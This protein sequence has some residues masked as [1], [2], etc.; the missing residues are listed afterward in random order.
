MPRTKR[1]LA[2]A[3]SNSSAPAPA[4]KKAS[5]ERASEKGNQNY[6]T[7]TVAELASMLKDLGLPHTGKKAELVQHLDDTSKTISRAGEAVKVGEPKKADEVS[8]EPR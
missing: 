6:K 3:D 2:E 5:P 8:E 7:K 1:T 4:A